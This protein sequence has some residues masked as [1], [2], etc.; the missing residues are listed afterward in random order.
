MSS[1]HQS[2]IANIQKKLATEQ[3]TQ[4]KKLELIT[5][6]KES[7]EI[8]EEIKEAIEQ[9]KTKEEEARKYL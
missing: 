8:L 3:T 2:D 5:E 9:M 6:V 1:M 4:M 7:S